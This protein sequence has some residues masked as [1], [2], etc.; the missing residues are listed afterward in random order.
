MTYPPPL[1]SRL[2]FIDGPVAI[3]IHDAPVAEIGAALE[4]LRRLVAVATLQLAEK[5]ESSDAPSR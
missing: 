1:E 2:A 4:R 3:F 5:Q